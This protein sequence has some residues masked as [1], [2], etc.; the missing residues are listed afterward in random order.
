MMLDDALAN[1]RDLNKAGLWQTM[2]GSASTSSFSLER[3]LDCD[4]LLAT[5]SLSFVTAAGTRLSSFFSVS[6]QRRRPTLCLSSLKEVNQDQSSPY[7]I[8]RSRN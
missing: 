1:T 4:S 2:G 5:F 8:F 3:V 7:A 6:F